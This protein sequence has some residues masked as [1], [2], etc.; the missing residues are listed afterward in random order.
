MVII[1]TIDLI[2]DVDREWHAIETLVTHAA[3]EAARMI[4]FAHGLQYL[5]KAKADVIL[6]FNEDLTDDNNRLSS[7]TISMIR[8]PQIAHFSAVCWKPEYCEHTKIL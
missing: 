7:F 8:W 6:Y 1:Y 3:P 2:V 4:R 5:R